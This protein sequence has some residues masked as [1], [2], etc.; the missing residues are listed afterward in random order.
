MPLVTLAE[1]AHLMH[2]AVSGALR[3]NAQTFDSIEQDAARHCASVAGIT[4]PT[5]PRPSTLDWIVLP[6]AWVIQYMAA[7]AVALTV[8]SDD[9]TMRHIERQYNHAQAIL[10]APHPATSPTNNVVTGT[11]EDLWP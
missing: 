2:N 6:M 10:R 3:S 5:G 4:L 7:P 11:F 9:A 1:T 8:S